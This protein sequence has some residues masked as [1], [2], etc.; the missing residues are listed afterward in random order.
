MTRVLDLALVKLINFKNIEP[1]ATSRRALNYGHNQGL[2]RLTMLMG[3]LMLLELAGVDLKE[4]PEK[5]NMILEVLTV[6]LWGDDIRTRPEKFG[7]V[8]PTHFLKPL[9]TAV[10]E[11][12]LTKNPTPILDWYASHIKRTTLTAFNVEVGEE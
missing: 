6:Q 3:N 8:S 4:D 10:A 7:D 1:T 12:T 9:G 11:Y 2:N 5:T